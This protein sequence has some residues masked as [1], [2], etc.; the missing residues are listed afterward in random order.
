MADFYSSVPKTLQANLAYRIDLRK[1]AALDAGFRRAILTACK[2]DA[3]YFY[4]AWCWVFEPRPEI[5]NGKKQSHIIPFI[6]WPHQDPV[7]LEALKHLGYEDIGIKKSRG[8]GGSWFAVSEAVRQWN[9]EPLA[10]IGLVSRNEAAVD[11]PLDPDSLFWKIDWLLSK[12]PKWMVGIKDVDWKRS[13]A[14]HSLVNKRNGSTI[15]GYAA[16]GDVASGGR[17][18]WFLMDELAKFPKGQDVDAMA[19]TQY[20][21]N[22]RL[23]ISTPKGSTGAYAKIMHTPGGIKLTLDWKDNPTRNRGLY[24]MKNDRPVAVDPVNNP[25]RPDY[26]PPSPAIL[27]LLSKLRREGFNVDNSIRSPWYDKQCDRFNATPT[28]VAQELDQDFG[29]SVQ[30]VFEH[31]F[32]KAADSTVSE[33]TRRGNLR[34]DQET[35]EP[36]FGTTDAGK[37]MLWTPLDKDGRPPK[38]SYAAGADICS[39]AGGEYTSNSAVVVYN[40]TTYEQ[41]AEFVVNTMKPDDFAD[42]CI[43][44]CKWFWDADLNCERNGGSGQ[45]FTNR[46]IEMLYPNVYRPVA[47]ESRYSKKRSRDIFWHSD[48]KKKDAV[49]G[50]FARSVRQSELK[51]RSKELARECGEYV[52]DGGVPVHEA[53]R[54]T[55]DEGQKGTAHGDRVIAAAVA[56]L[57]IRDRTSIKVQ[58]KNR[59][60]S[61]INPPYGTLAWREKHHDDLLREENDPWDQ[62][63]TDDLASGGRFRSAS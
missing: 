26:D 41:V 35:L 16:T 57:G 18:A 4:N 38:G 32:F 53:E 5:V 31:E 2:H 6:T 49:I 47:N 9:F 43:A 1:R 45:T 20:V 28:S 36:E 14:E 63:T 54:K 25:L 27:D 61:I 23:V 21:T 46:V 62:R 33:P 37:V 58:E 13:I 55:M 30:R 59:H 40:K 12:L 10:T 39:G 22:S 15:T 29:G 7:F 34:F 56:W 48:P 17:K 52:W 3:M 24:T 8:E 60:H 19:S 11:S 42:F 44:L 50:A 51:I